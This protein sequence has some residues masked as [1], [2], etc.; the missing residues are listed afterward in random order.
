MSKLELFN[1]NFS[2]FNNPIMYSK[3]RMR[4]DT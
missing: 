1:K 4:E 3:N 2:G